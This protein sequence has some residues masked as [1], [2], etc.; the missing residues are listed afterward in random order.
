MNTLFTQECCNKMLAHI[1]TVKRLQVWCLV[2]R[3]IFLVL[4]FEIFLY[5]ANIQ[6]QKQHKEYILGLANLEHDKVS[7]APEK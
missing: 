7:L 4:E 3:Q 5:L 6:C 1:I 2:L